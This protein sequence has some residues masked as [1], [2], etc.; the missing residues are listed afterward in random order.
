M[1][2]PEALIEVHNR[3]HQSLQKLLAHCATLTAD[4]LNREM[5]AFGD[6]TV[7]LQLHH[8][9]SAERYWIGV[10]EGRMD[11]DEDQADYPTAESLETF[12]QKVFAA[13]ESYLRAA[14][15]EELN[16]PRPMVT[17]GNK[18]RILIP[19]HIVVR[20]QM[21]IYHHFGK[22]GAMCRLMGKPVP[23][24]MDYPIA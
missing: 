23:P 11:V 9:I 8:V 5:D 19:A 21:H 1:F 4:E 24:G 14:S 10:I 20:T 2:T 7:Q 15:V 16:T 18:E 22:V 12:R 3:A 13:G 17:W 6:P